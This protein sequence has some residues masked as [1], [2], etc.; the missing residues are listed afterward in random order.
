MTTEG[1]FGRPPSLAE[2]GDGYE[3]W[4]KL[5][6]MWSKFTTFAKNKQASVIAVK[7]LKGEAQSVA[8]A[9]EDSELED[10]EGVKKL[11]EELDKLYMKDKDM[12]GYESW[13][14]ISKYKRPANST[15]LSYCAEYRR[16][17]S[18]AKK[19]D[20]EVS[21]TTFSFML[22][23]NS[24]FSEEQKMLI[25][26]IAL[27]KATDTTKMAPENVESAM[28]RIQSSENNNHTSSSEVFEAEYVDECDFDGMSLTEGEKEELA[29]H[30]MFTMQSKRHNNQSSNWNK[31]GRKHPYSQRYSNKYG[32]SYS[33][34]KS[35]ASQQ[36][37]MLNPKDI[38][39]GEII[40]CH[41]CNSRFHM[42][43]SMKCPKNA[44]ALMA[45]E[46]GIQDTMNAE[47]IFAS[48]RDFKTAQPQATNGRGVV[49]SAATKTVCGQP[50][51]EA[52]RN[53]LVTLGKKVITFPS[54]V[55]YKFGNDGH[56]KS[57]FAAAI[58]VK[59]FGREAKLHVD[60]ISSNCPLLMG[61]P[62]LER[63]G[64]ILNFRESTAIV[65][66]K[67]YALER[68]E[69]GHYLV[70]LMF[71]N[72]ED[73]CVPDKNIVAVGDEVLCA[74]DEAN[75]IF[76]VEEESDA[77]CEIVNTVTS[78]E[79]SVD[80][81]KTARKLHLVFGHPTSKRLIENIERV[82]RNP[83]ETKALCEAV[84]K[85]TDNCKTCLAL[86]KHKPKPKV[87]LPLANK[88]ND[89]LAFDLTFWN[90]ILTKKIVCI[91][92]CIDLA[93]RLSA[94]CVA[95]SKDPKHIVDNLVK[96]WLNVFGAP[97]KI[98]TDNGGEFANKKLV[99]L[100]ENLGIEFKATAAESSFSNGINER[101][102]A[103][104]KSILDKIRHDHNK[105]SVDIVL[106]YAVFAKNCL[107]DN[108]GFSP[109]QR[110]FGRSPNI[111]TICSENICSTNT[112][113]ESED[114]MNHLQLLHK[115]RQ[116]YMT[117]ESDDRIK[118]ALRSRVYASDAPFFYGERVF[119][120]RESK[121][122][123]VR[124]WKGPG[125]VIGSEGKVVV[126]RHGSFIQ[127]MHETKV[128]RSAE[129][130][131]LSKEDIVEISDESDMCDFPDEEVAV[132][133]TQSSADKQILIPV[134]PQ[135]NTNIPQT[136]LNVEPSSSSTIDT[137]DPQNDHETKTQNS[138]I[139]TQSIEKH[140]PESQ[141][142]VNNISDTE[143]TAAKNADVRR[144]LRPREN[145]KPAPKYGFDEAF[146]MS[147]SFHEVYT[148]D[149][150]DIRNAKITELQSW[151]VHGVFKE[152]DK[153]EATSPLITTRWILTDKEDIDKTVYKKARLVIRGF[154][155]VDKD[156][157]ISESPTAHTESLKMMLAVLPTLGFRPKKID[158]STAFLQGKSLCR[159]VFIKPP[160]EADVIDGK[161]WMLL[162][163]VYGLTDASRMWYERVNE[164]L[165]HGGF[166]RSL[167]DPALYFKYE[168]GQ[169]ISVVLFHVDDFLYSGI[170]AEISKF[171]ELITKSFAV[172]G[173]EERKFMFCG[174]QI[175]IIECEADGEFQIQYCQ[176][177][178]IVN[179][180]P[181]I[182]IQPTDPSAYASPAEES[183]FR[184]VLGALQW[185]GNST[186][187]DLTFGVSKLLGETKS[188]QVK[189]CILA[190][191][192]LRKAKANDPV[193]IASKKLEGKLA[194][195][196]YSDASY[197]NLSNGGSQR[198][199]ISFLS[200]GEGNQNVVEYKSN[201]IKRVCRSTFG[202]ELL[203]CNASVDLALYHRAMTKCFGLDVSIMMH[204]D[205]RSVRDNLS[206]LVSRCE[207]KSLRIEL[208][209][210][211][212]VLSKEGIKI[213]WIHTS[214]QLAD[215]LTKEKPGLQ[216][217]KIVSNTD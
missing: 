111:P 162:K 107:V 74:V 120:W 42:Y 210:L 68:S 129:G 139:T 76:F 110:V 156:S 173:I 178:K 105:T 209:Y 45:E 103:I 100:I 31:K 49:D 29:E 35:Y 62:T 114:M 85:F 20:I 66:D 43:R 75:E 176:P 36:G 202:A 106:S 124:G 28:R 128:R 65:D 216:I 183:G 46:H 141:P 151:K 9:M 153:A 33:P 90:D 54:D 197:G 13:K 122:K 190:N 127:R 206:S 79:N 207:E 143:N 203:A 145:I 213:K 198:G 193:K 63:I 60:V 167:V 53:Y 30:A 71:E 94:A 168:K 185:H 10:D 44:K 194:L 146:E 80:V 126:I 208:S 182:L 158:I 87:C 181:I 23:D 22:L 48:E 81:N 165:V 125:T 73:Q 152:I 89:V 132:E 99:E 52:Y 98:Y 83:K 172:R 137:V 166:Q 61:R 6:K 26:S 82:N 157:V 102:H 119:Y 159:P 17:R 116:A 138:D 24:G 37:P 95:N 133:S 177:D 164:V 91:L 187:P 51:F 78:T 214:E 161:C 47:T 38:Q 4:K 118:R 96:T 130:G 86:A 135:I 148:S 77:A 16:I 59:L 19:Y 27:S 131:A 186:R 149:G 121:D 108:L 57:L 163:G 8:L 113:L 179:I 7:A 191:K 188:L 192:L 175:E 58:P 136:G 204:I 184:S 67:V 200:D 155:D 97:V 205:S 147:D 50:W 11:L 150:D 142:K 5:V 25:L 55:L 70:S 140:I 117:A 88:F 1:G 112:E 21:D 109:H 56:K 211:R 170:D 72:L 15:I 40:R 39:T 212:E 34:K 174:F 101:H 104:I 93:T 169:V 84:S 199:T 189:H 217:L 2:S 195:N 154:Q 41:G 180:Q 92:H 69:K 64:L 3:E 144:V 160:P 32:D 134:I 18:E 14:K 215:I 171:E 115:T 12:L 196:V 201:R 123:A